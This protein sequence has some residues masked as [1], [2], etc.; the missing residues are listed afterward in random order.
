MEAHWA[1][2]DRGFGEYEV[3]TI[4]VDAVLLIQWEARLGHNPTRAGKYLLYSLT[5]ANDKT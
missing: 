4:F 5:P 2:A 3:L 1:G